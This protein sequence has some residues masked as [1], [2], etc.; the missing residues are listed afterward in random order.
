MCQAFEFQ[1][2]Y[3]LTTAKHT[4]ICLKEITRFR[5]QIMLFSCRCKSCLRIRCRM[6]KI[7]NLILHKRPS[8]SQLPSAQLLRVGF[9][10][11]K[12][13]ATKLVY[14]MSFPEMTLRMI[15]SACCTWLQSVSHSSLSFDGNLVQRVIQ[16]NVVWKGIQIPVCRTRTHVR[17]PK[18]IQSRRSKRRKS[19]KHSK[20]KKSCTNKK[21]FAE[22][23]EK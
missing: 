15:C 19:K 21:R 14:Q 12:D 23:A 20:S 4:P 13:A 2:Q 3:L 1:D 17:R 16:E 9:G 5:R 10:D 22:I 11:K 6:W 18:E 8:K 7:Q